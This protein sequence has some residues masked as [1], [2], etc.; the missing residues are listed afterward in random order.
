MHGRGPGR[1][2]AQLTASAVAE[3]AED[4]AVG[5]PDQSGAGWVA[6]QR[7][8]G[9][10]ERGLAGV[11]I[12][13]GQPILPIDRLPQLARQRC[14]RRRGGGF[15]KRRE[16]ALEVGIAQQSREIER[17]ARL[18]VSPDRL[19]EPP[20]SARGERPAQGVVHGDAAVGERLGHDCGQRRVGEAHGH[21]RSL[22]AGRLTPEVGERGL[23]L[24]RDHPGLTARTLDQ[25]QRFPRHRHLPLAPRVD[26]DTSPLIEERRLTLGRRHQRSDERRESV[27]EPALE[28]AQRGETAE[29]DARTR[30]IDLGDRA[31]ARLLARARRPRGRPGA[32]RWG[33][34]GRCARSLPAPRARGRPTTA[35]APSHR[36]RRSPPRRAQGRRGSAGPPRPA[37]PDTAPGR[38]RTR[39]GPR[40]RPPVRAPHTRRARARAGWRSGGS[41]DRRAREALPPSR[42]GAERSPRAPAA[43]PTTATRCE[44]S[45]RPERRP[46]T[47]TTTSSRRGSLSSS[48]RATRGSAGPSH[49]RKTRATVTPR[50]YRE[51]SSGPL[52][53][54]CPLDSQHN[55]EN[56]AHRRYRLHRP[57]SRRSR[58]VARPRGPSGQPKA[59]A[60]GLRLV[61]GEPRSGSG[62]DG[63]DR[64]S[65]R[66]EPVRASAGPKR[67]RRC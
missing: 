33:R 31:S 7:T 27:E 12:E 63:R 24:R 43:P 13:S 22:A 2:R 32:P 51:P 37:R 48:Q 36:R 66:R 11:E 28:T 64:P 3:F 57:A 38:E 9:R 40:C 26:V 16:M 61:A 50:W 29:H 14:G 65:R 35:N 5:G 15:E 21:A 52:Q 47:T 17:R 44:R 55:Y 4:R 45:S 1:D 25:R 8:G 58:T 20:G 18:V 53:S 23:D 39:S 42:C 34:S 60:R 46:G 49:P 54:E 59:G 67:R 10:F 62:R 56:P 19:Q 41:I 6:R 30:R